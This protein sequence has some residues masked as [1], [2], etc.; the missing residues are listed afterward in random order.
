MKSGQQLGAAQAAYTTAYATSRRER[1]EFSDLQGLQRAGV[2][3]AG[4]DAGID[5]PGSD[6]GD[7]DAVTVQLESHS[8]GECRQGVLGSA[9]DHAEPVDLAGRDRGHDDDVARRRSIIDLAPAPR[10]P[11]TSNAGQWSWAPNIH[12]RG[13]TTGSRFSRTALSARW[14]GMSATVRE[15][16]ASNSLRSPEKSMSERANLALGWSCRATCSFRTCRHKLFLPQTM[17]DAERL[18][19][20]VGR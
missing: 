13:V 17:A 4:T 18:S 5:H 2:I 19:R 15:F 6:F 20:S 10:M 7:L 9:I 14:K 11:A 12:R 1:L 3:A 8:A 16:R